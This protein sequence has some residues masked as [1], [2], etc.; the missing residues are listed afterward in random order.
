MTF[1]YSLTKKVSPPISCFVNS[2]LQ[3]D[4][5]KIY[6]VTEVTRDIKI[7]LEDSFP[8][9]WLT[10]EVSN[11]KASTAG[12]CYFTLKDE[13]AQIKVVMFRGA[14][15]SLKFQIEDG[16]ELI[17]HGR[18]TVYDARGEYQ[19]LADTA[20]PKGFGALQLAFEQLKKR[21]ETE[22][23]F[24][25]RHKK[26]L[27]FLPRRVGLVT[28]SQGA[29]LHDMLN[30]MKRRFPNI[31]VV[32]NPVKVQGDGAAQE[33]AHAIQE[34]NLRDDIDVL[35]VGRGGGSLEDLWAFNEE[36]LVRAVFESR[37]PIVSAVG[38]ETDYTLCDL[39]ADVRAPTPSA[40]AELVVPEKQELESQVLATKIELANTIRRF[41]KKYSEKLLFLKK[42]L[43]DPRR[44][45]ADLRLK[46]NDWEARL[47]LS[48]RMG[49][50]FKKKEVE[51][52]HYRWPD[53]AQKIREHQGQLG[54]LKQRLIHLSPYEI[55]KKG[56]SL[57]LEEGTNKP[58][59][60]V[61]QLVPGENYTLKMED[62]S[63]LVKMLE[64]IKS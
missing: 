20:E 61:G 11:F 6:S 19:L 45:Y 7:L 26:P 58:V 52:I 46:L 12:H 13:G 40:A 8:Q 37:I 39:V 44:Y 15:R 33:V 32:I 49:L 63:A 62:G 30:V 25:S 4:V 42:G 23:L 50:E 64:I 35:I 36:V 56:Y 41:L 5:R 9:V 60:S 24:E 21:L 31:D 1:L 18:I 38:H 27:P 53:M 34:L 51:T 48:I 54:Q 28:S 14:N 10:G 29:V 43:K 59:D 55:F 2:L 3:T 22:G 16:Q 17:I 47:V 57:L